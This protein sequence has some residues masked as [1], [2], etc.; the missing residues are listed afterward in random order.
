MC[1]RDR[2]TDKRVERLLLATDRLLEE[3]GKVLNE[4]HRLSKMDSGFLTLSL[5]HICNGLH[6]V[7]LAALHDHKAV[8]HHAAKLESQGA[9][10][11]GG[12]FGTLSL[13]HI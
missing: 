10:V 6:F 11:H 9:A 12:A 2:L 8:R 13:I 4:L 1:I 7:H 3:Q 5:I